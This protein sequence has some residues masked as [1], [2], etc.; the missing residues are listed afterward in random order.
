MK[1]H[2]GGVTLTQCLSMRVGEILLLEKDVQIEKNTYQYPFKGEDGSVALETTATT[3]DVEAA[4]YTNGSVYKLEQLPDGSFRTEIEVTKPDAYLL[5]NYEASITDATVDE[6]EVYEAID[7]AGLHAPQQEA[8]D[9]I[10]AALAECTDKAAEL[11]L[12]IML[13]DD[14]SSDEGKK[15]S[16]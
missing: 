2:P 7:T 16:L 15:G 8:V 6:D 14:D 10:L 12:K 9:F 3:L 4:N 1:T 5:A 11:E 13:E